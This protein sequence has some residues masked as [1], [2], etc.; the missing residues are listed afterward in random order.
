[1]TLVLPRRIFIKG[2]ASLVASPALVRAESLMPVKVWTPPRDSLWG[3][4]S[5]AVLSSEDP[6]QWSESDWRIAKAESALPPLHRTMAGKL[7]LL[8]S[9]G[10]GRELVY[11]PA[12]E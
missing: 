8:L 9:G 7:Y 5:F 3:I 1:M 12:R 4:P 11:T 2:L 10:G 6:S